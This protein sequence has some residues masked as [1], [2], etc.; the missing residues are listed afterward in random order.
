M[1]D[2]HILWS[3][4]PDLLRI[5]CIR[6]SS[7][8]VFVYATVPC[9]PR[10]KLLNHTSSDYSEI[11][12]MSADERNLV[13][14][15]KRRGV[16]RASITRI[17]RRVS[18]LEAKEE[19][20]HGDLLTV[21]GLLHKLNGLDTDFK[22]YH[23]AIVDAVEDELEQDALDE[24]DDRVSLLTT[25]AQRLIAPQSS[26]SVRGRTGR[27]S[28]TC[29]AETYTQTQQLS[30]LLDRLEKKLKEIVDS[31]KAAEA[32]DDVDTCVMLQ[33]EEQLSVYKSELSSVSRDILSIEGTDELAGKES[34]LSKILFDACV[35]VKRLLRRKPQ[36]TLVH[37]E[38][39]GV[40]LPKLDVPVFD[41]NIVNWIP[42]W[43]QFR[44]SV[45]DRGKLSDP[46]KLAYLKHALK[47]GRAKTVVEGLS[48]S[49]ENYKEAVDTLRKC[50]DRPR[51][52]HQAHVRAIVDAPSL[53]DGNGRE[54]RRLHDA[55]SRHLQALKTMDCEPSGS[56]V[57]SLLELKLDTT[58]MF[59]YSQE[60]PSVPHY[61]TLLELI[62]LRAQA[63]ESSVFDLKR[64][65]GH[66]TLASY[67][68]STEEANCVACKETKHPLYVCAKFRDLP[69]EQRNSL[70]K[71]RSLCMNCLKPG[72][73]IKQC[74]SLQRCRKCQKTHHTLLHQDDKPPEDK[75]PP[76]ST[77]HSHTAQNSTKSQQALLM[78]SRVLVVSPG[79][80]TTQARAL[81]DSASSTSFISERLAQRLHLPR[82]HETL[83]FAGIGGLTHQSQRRSIASFNITSVW[84]KSQ[85]IPVE[86]VVLPK[87]PA[88][89]PYIPFPFILSGTIY[90]TSDLQ[91]R[92]LGFPVQLIFLDLTCS[93]MCYFMAGSTAA[94]GHQL[95]LRHASAGC[96]LAAFMIWII[97][98]GDLCLTMCRCQLSLPLPSLH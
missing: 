39:G 55:V 45:H 63:S 9:V 8:S 28:S 81:L 33:Y 18:E 67:S 62:S 2:A 20:T 57:T 71:S 87:S 69:L 29:T 95:P 53:K 49:G 88:T 56:F 36:H 74:K 84:S 35:S 40:K 73:F 79:G 4:E 48:D 61:S 10:G 96:W 43:E 70:V 85:N 27:P 72:H 26:D 19:L 97:N 38:E 16:V 41:G 82:S 93:A 46:E 24:H 52:I 77:V 80:P 98:K 22:S 5:G 31:I 12:E 90:I 32:G 58:T 54:L 64:G 94:R 15:R 89:C 66:R 42:F 60:A 86:A 1:R 7:H 51:L 25:R 44:I 14:N 23:F 68:A 76:T 75:P 21:Q 83:Q 34:E 59:E 11:F 47:D 92:S 17:A 37:G 30:R 6:L 50:Y 3:F 65:P 78:T 13:T 91:I